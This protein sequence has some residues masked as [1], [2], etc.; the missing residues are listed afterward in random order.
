MASAPD[1]SYRALLAA[2]GL[3]RALVSME[4]GRIAQAMLPVALVLL[5]ITNFASPALAGA[6]TFLCVF[7]GLIA[8]PFVGA[9][10]DRL[11]KVA[12]IRIDYV[13]GAVLT[14]VMAVLPLA[15]PDVVP[16]LLG[17]TIGLGVTQLF[18]DA[19]FRS[20][21][22]DI[23]PTHLWERANAVDSSGYQVAMIAGPP[24]AA[25]LFGLAGAQVTFASVAI[26][27]GVSALLTIGLREPL[28]EPTPHT[29]ILRSALIG[30]VYIWR[31]QTL[32][33]M[34]I[35]VSVT[36][37]PLGIVTIVVPILIVDQL[38]AS[39]A[40]VGVAF[41]LAG[42]VGIAAA[43]AIGRIDTRGGRDRWLIIGAHAVVTIAAVLLLPVE[44]AG[45]VAGM[46][47]I[48]A[49]MAVRGGGEA[50][51]DLG[52][53]TMRQRRTDKHMMG[54]AF[55]ISMA[56]NYSGVPVGAAL[57]GWL[58]GSA[59]VTA[60]LAVAIGFGLVGTV[61]SYVLLPRNEVVALVPDVSVQET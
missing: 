53:F 44:G 17:L 55:A 5:A 6:L 9:L 19:G 57:G 28:S 31:N 32:R 24:I 4:T 15:S 21:L 47:W 20:L 12:S 11:G 61:L 56:L 38:G 48:L 26:A 23:A 36:G 50:A 8:A 33:G 43:V 39:E 22:P 30:L 59:G 27:Y 2:P 35:S 60:A 29:H 49:S 40:L 52:V 25:T 41:A 13:T 34:A 3:F 42:V 58:I 37:I 14:A 51:S 10:I 18:S 46:V 54:R 16:L 45:L 1:R 7:P